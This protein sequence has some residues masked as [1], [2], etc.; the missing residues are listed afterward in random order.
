MKFLY[1]MAVDS[2]SCERE[3]ERGSGRM[4]FYVDGREGA[5]ERW[6]GRDRRDE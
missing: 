1:T 4:T 2:C 5:W 3:H 6:D